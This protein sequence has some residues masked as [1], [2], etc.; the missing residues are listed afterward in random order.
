MSRRGRTPTMPDVL[1]EPLVGAPGGGQAINGL[2][3]SEPRA[4]DRTQAYTML[5]GSRLGA[6]FVVLV[7]GAIYA[8]RRTSG[9]RKDQTLPYIAGANITTLADTLV[10]AVLL[11]NPDA[12]RVVLAEM[13]GVTAWT[14]VL[15]GILYP[16]SGE[17]SSGS[18]GACWLRGPASPAP[19]RCS[20]PSRS[21]WWCPD[22]LVHSP[23]R[24]RP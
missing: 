3:R 19:W 6:S 14:L 23:T 9:R 2:N 20:W 13:L 10:A 12:S 16:A 11:D 7:V 18:P 22:P 24:W 1:T 21:P 5:T 17:R 4:I 15:L 8:F